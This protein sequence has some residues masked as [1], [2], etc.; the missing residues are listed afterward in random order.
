MYIWIIY[1]KYIHRLYIYIYQFS[2]FLHYTT[3]MNDQ[4]KAARRLA[5]YNCELS[6]IK[7]C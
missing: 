6:T 2:Q 3:Y 4:Y 5:T 1:V 7:S